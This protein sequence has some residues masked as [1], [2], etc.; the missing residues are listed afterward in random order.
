MA[1][2]DPPTPRYDA[3]RPT[4]WLWKLALVIVAVIGGFIALIARRL[5]DPAAEGTIRRLVAFALVAV[6]VCAIS[7]TAQRWI[8]R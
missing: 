5:P 7:A 3:P 1:D 4:A 8:N 2:V 6:G